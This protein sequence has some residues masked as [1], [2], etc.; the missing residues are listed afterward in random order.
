MNI[1]SIDTQTIAKISLAPTFLSLETFVLLK[2]ISSVCFSA[3]KKYR[4]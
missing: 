1:N 2:C 4:K 3:E